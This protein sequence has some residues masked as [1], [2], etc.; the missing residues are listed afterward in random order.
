MSILRSL[1]IRALAT[2]GSAMVLE[3]A[4]LDVLRAA[5][6]VTLP[7]AAF[8]IL[9]VLVVC[10]LVVWRPRPLPLVLGR[11]GGDSERNGRSGWA[12]RQV[13]LSCLAS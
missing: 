12:A 8:R 2:K 9:G 4:S 5:G 7:G 3:L 11:L 13:S 1:R 6:L 10:L